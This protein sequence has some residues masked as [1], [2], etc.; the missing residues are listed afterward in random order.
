MSLIHNLYDNMGKK[1]RI[2]PPIRANL[3]FSF[4]FFL[5][6]RLYCLI[7]ASKDRP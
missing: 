7:F 5:D 2:I 1:S 6:F 4:T 3:L